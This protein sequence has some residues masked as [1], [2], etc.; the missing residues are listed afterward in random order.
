MSNGPPIALIASL[1]GDPARANMLLAL[2]GGKALTAS[3]LANEAGVTPQTASGHLA[4]LLD[5]GLVLCVRQGRHRYFRLSSPEIADLLES[6]MGIAVRRGRAKTWT[7]PRDQALRRARVCYDH[8]AGEVAVKLTDGLVSSRSLAVKDGAFVLTGAGRRF[9]CDFGIHIAALEQQRRPLCR[10]CLDW[11]ERRSHLGGALGAA[12]L[13]R[14][15]ALGWMRRV[16]GSR[17]VQVTPKG[18][19]GLRRLLAEAGPRESSEVA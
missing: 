8:L 11:S 16:A 5:G 7:G 13:S 1:I 3:E 19:L 15:E 18:Q 12:L 4:R 2:M 6:L 10:A 14:F 9:L 17:I